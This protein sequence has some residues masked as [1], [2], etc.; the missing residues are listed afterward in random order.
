MFKCKLL[1]L[2]V[3][4]GL[5]TTLELPVRANIVINEVGR[6]L[7]PIAATATLA[8]AQNGA[9]LLQQAKSLYE[10]GQFQEAA[11]VLQEAVNALAAAGDM[12]SQG[13]ALGN[14]ALVYL[15]LGMWQEA[16]QAINQS[17]ALVSLNHGSDALNVLAKT[18]NIQGQMRLM[19]GQGEAAI[20]SWQQAGEIAAKIGDKDGIIEAKINQS[21]AMQ[22]LGLYPKACKTL[23]EV[24]AFDN[25]GVC[26]VSDDGI[27][28]FLQLYNPRE[29]PFGSQLRA[30]TAL[31]DVLRVVGQLDKS[32]AV[33]QASLQLG[34]KF[35]INYELDSL[36]LSLG[37]TAEAKKEIEA[38]VSFYRQA[39]ALSSNSTVSIR[40]KL[41][42][43]HLAVDEDKFS[44]ADRS[45]LLTLEEATSLAAVLKEEI[46]NLPANRASIY[47]QINLANSLIEIYQRQ[48]EAKWQ[49]EAESLLT[50]AADTARSMGDDRATAYALGMRGSLYEKLQQY[51]RAE[52][53]TIEALN[54]APKYLAPDIAYQFLWQAGRISKA[55]GNVEDSIGY[56]TEAVE[57]LQSIRTDLVAIS[58]DAQFDFRAQV[59]PVYREL[60][61]LLLQ[62]GRKDEQAKLIKARQLIESLQLAELDNFFKDACL[63]T[64]AALVD[65]IDPT[66]AVLYPIILEDRLEVI[67]ALP[68]QP[69]RHYST[70]ISKPEIEKIVSDIR[71]TLTN[72]RRQIRLEPLQTAYNWLLRP[73]EQDLANSNIKTLVFVPDGGLRNIPL[74][75]LYDGER[76]LVEKYSVAI[77]PGLQLVDPKPLDRSQLQL[78]AVG[79]TEARQGFTALPGV[80]QEFQRIGEQIP[81]K[82]L[83]ND[84][85]TQSNFQQQLK[86]FPF[87]VIHIGTHGEFSS[88]AED[89]FIL[90]WNDRINV[91]ELDELLR[92]DIQQRGAG[93]IELL[94]L[95]ACKTAA[96]DDRAA[97]GLAGVAVRAGAR[98]TVASLWS[99][100]DEATAE[101]MSRFY[102]ELTHSQVTKAEA[103]RRAQEAVLQNPN[104]AHPYF[105][106]AFV[107]VGNW[108]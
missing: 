98:S 4:L 108:L 10:Q 88:K 103:L 19:M 82:V 99:V 106:S 66:A 107:M 12:L 18:L 54:L 44:A 37:N 94:V 29:D 77:A 100:S 24:L 87:P 96:G 16:E 51:S 22:D 90:T 1:A 81:T 61:G 75:A 13:A 27:N 41:D 47:A 95:S 70:K 64:Q 79:L 5:A 72:R 7:S 3:F 67:L 52:M 35:G 21:Q 101:L 86:T 33:L 36:Y 45:S 46:K 38:A 80:G 15:Q 53:D 40:A 71:A 74:T 9:Q 73:I 65:E 69:L 83:L 20:D 85:F 28:T 104:F 97:L 91:N 43:L 42:L 2:G 56:Y 39:A 25:Q 17:L 50:Q 62:P 63:N 57:T 30:L 23:L 102:H 48:P 76:Y 93:T 60:V 31:G 84:A 49:M 89:T 32:A 78:I 11:R 26:A 34:A 8:D 68:G 6:E 105:W 55:R 92:G 14:L 58:S 59:E